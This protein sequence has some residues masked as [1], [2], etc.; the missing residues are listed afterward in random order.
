MATKIITHGGGFHSDEVFAIALIKEYFDSDIEVVRTRDKT[1]LKEVLECGDTWVIDVGGEFAPEK[2][3][4]DHHQNTFND[5]WLASDILFSSCGLV[6]M[7]LK[8][9]GYLSKHLSPYQINEFEEKLIK[10]IDLHDNGAG[11]WQPS[12]VFKLYN[13]E[14]NTLE[15]FMEVVATA[16]RY[17]QN[18]AYHFKTEEE[19][20]S[21]LYDHTYL[22]S[23]K[24][25]IVTNG[26]FNVIPSV[27]KNT[28]S[29]VAIEYKEDEDTWSVQCVRRWVSAPEAWRGLSGSELEAVSGIQGMIFTHRA[30]HLVKVSNKDSA[31]A[32]A[33]SILSN[34]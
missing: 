3:N 34:T 16:V 8:S 18:S 10:R 13:R 7:Y 24:I 11:K 31:I 33:R 14:S 4:F 2:K 19:N 26:A 17:I 21:S 32:V 9:N 25:A 27:V 12:L 22:D 29:Q 1:F 20:Q 5:K 28:P 15:N 30:G 6:W 23:G